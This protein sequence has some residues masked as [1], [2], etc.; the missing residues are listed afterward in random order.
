MRSVRKQISVF[1]LLFFLSVLCSIPSDIQGQNYQ[2]LS[3]KNKKAEKLFREAS[4][5]Y[6]MKEYDKALISLGK[7]I[8]TDP[9]FIEAYILSGDILSDQQKI[10][11]AVSSYR[12]ALAIR[13]DYSPNLYYILA[14]LQYTYGYYAAAKSDFEKYLY[15]ERTPKN[16]R[17]NS[18][19]GITACEFALDALKNPVPFN[20]VSLGDSINTEED[21]FVNAITADDQ[22]LYFTR[23]LLKRYDAQN[24]KAYYEEDF[25]YSV[26]NQD[27]VWRSALNLGPPINTMWNEGA[28]TIS[29]DGRYL[30]FAGCQRPGGY[31][32]CDLYWS[33]RA[34]D[35]WSEPE[36]LGPEVNSAA[37]ESQ[38]SFSSDGSTLYFAST[39]KGGKGSS[40]IWRTSLNPDG[41]WTIPINLGDSVN[42]PLEEQTPFIHPDNQN[43]YFASRGFT[44]MGG[45]DLFHSRTDKNGNLGKAQNLG[46]PINTFAD[47]FALILNAKG[48]MAYIS[49]DKL[50]GKG[51]MDIYR[52]VLYN[53][54]R[55][56]PV[57]YFKGVVF[58][59]ETKQLLRADFELTDLKSGKTIARS[60]SDSLTGAFML[61]L[62]TDYEY[63]L[64]VSKPGYLFYSDHFSLIGS[65]S[66][67]NPFVR[68][69]PLHEVMVGES[70]ILK[71]IFF[72]T[73]KFEIKPES[74]VEL[75]RLI[76]LL[77]ENAKIRIELSGHTDNIGMRDHNE[78]LS[79]N[80]ARAVFDYLAG[81]GIAK[82]R[83]SFTGYG[84]SRPIDTNDTEQGR[85]N[86]RR[87]E[88]KIIGN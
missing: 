45:A 82:E 55:P 56:N 57:T 72:D 10:P 58:N 81:H 34:G 65:H 17:D 26:R 78:T 76:R 13:P 54:A 61:I 53:K 7:A 77:L 60:F 59:S 24:D 75:Q 12:S 48:D 3:T 27:S 63:A 25:F 71:N 8:K 15:F 85:A 46:Y 30:F 52:F 39:R 19:R 86:N 4:D 74:E 62:P 38:P 11:E 79:L 31:G 43:L 5:Q 80:R 66:A 50:G 44:G 6:N 18:L 42:T 37:W 51:K 68:N 41:T 16:K 84:F 23:K 47:E 83:L 2:A 22:V 35:Q 29:P 67:D 69:I 36:N 87:T 1:L 32:S 73:D 14:N 64:S 21:E 40:D 70:V 20:P 88:F 49:S 28:L 33:K 9:E